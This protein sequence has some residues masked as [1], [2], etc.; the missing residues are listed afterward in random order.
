VKVR[1]DY[2]PAKNEN[3]LM[4]D[5]TVSK[6]YDKAYLM[7]EGHLLTSALNRPRLESISDTYIILSGF[8]EAD[9]VYVYREWHCKVLI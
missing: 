7:R 4:G 2:Q 3:G 1:I 6:D 5:L 8:E 9:N